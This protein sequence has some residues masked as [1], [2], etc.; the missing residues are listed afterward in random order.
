MGRPAKFSRD[1][2]LD[3]ALDLVAE[4]GPGAVTMSAIASRLDAPTGSLYHRF[5]S[6]DLLLSALWLRSVR[7][8]QEGFV[9]ALEAGD[10]EA[11]A[12][13]TPRWCRA[14]PAEAALLLLHRRKDLIRHPP[15]GEGMDEDVNAR[16]MAALDA[17]AAAHPGIDRRRLMFAVVDVPYGGVR[18]YLLDGRPPPALVDKLIVA[19]CRAV[20][21][22]PPAEAGPQ[23]RS[24][25]EGR[26]T[27]AQ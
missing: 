8:F 21:P 25:E 5:G 24:T 11:A 15:P 7:G 27:H 12:L 16:V 22:D 14:H 10:A 13:H 6:R 18:R 4:G 3:A 23:K 19:T 1:Q 9:A 20:L 26:V 2:I 17:Y